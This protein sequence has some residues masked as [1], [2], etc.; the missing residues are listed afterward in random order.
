[1]C[2]NLMYIGLLGQTTTNAVYCRSMAISFELSYLTNTVWAYA[3][4]RPISLSGPLVVINKWLRLFASNMHL[5]KMPIHIHSFLLRHKAISW[6]HHVS[7]A[8]KEWQTALLSL[9]CQQVYG[10]LMPVQLFASLPIVSFSL[11]NK[12][13]DVW[14]GPGRSL[15]L[16]R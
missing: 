9:C 10:S 3:N 8:V 7:F 12:L 1:M 14:D 11:G 6:C 15:D 13:T 4:S 2:T 16:T 5:Y